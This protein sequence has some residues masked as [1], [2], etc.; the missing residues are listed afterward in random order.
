MTSSPVAT[1]VLASGNPGKLR[2][3]QDC[4]G[5][6]RWSVVGLGGLGQVLPCQET[7]STFEENARLKAVYYSG[8]SP[9]LTLA[10]D[11]GLVVDALEGRPGVLSARF[12]S[13]DATDEQRYLE[14]LRQL[15]N[16]PDA[17]RTARFVCCLAL[18]RNGQ[19]LSIFDGVVEGVI[20]R[21]PLGSQGFG[22]DPIFYLPELGRTMAELEPEEKNRSSHRGRAL[23]KL[24][25]ELPA[26]AVTAPG[27]QHQDEDS[28]FQENP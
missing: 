8:F 12:V 25:A 20:A 16:V 28:G 3:L 11:S 1:L 5:S 26:L 23:R 24:M 27:N 13:P 22:Y 18:A 7:G 10:D 6:L 19:V 21:A 15:Q 17:E 4:L 14:V 9:H 2:E